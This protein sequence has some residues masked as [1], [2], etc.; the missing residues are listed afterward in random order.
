MT[1]V[2]YGYT[3]ST[4]RLHKHTLIHTVMCCTCI[5]T[6][7]HNNYVHIYTHLCT[8][9]HTMCTYTH[10]LIILDRRWRSLETVAL[11]ESNGIHEGV[12]HGESGIHV[13]SQ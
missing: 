11:G 1:S 8:Y 13:P 6:H 7:T 5:R 2:M 3:V 10:S 4:L 9:T 12:D